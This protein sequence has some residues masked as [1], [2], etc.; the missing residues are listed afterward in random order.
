MVRR[1][2]ENSVNLLACEKKCLKV[3]QLCKMNIQLNKYTE[4]NTNIVQ[5]I[6]I[7]KIKFKNVLTTLKAKYII[8]SS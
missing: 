7:N 3:V 5:I 1:A 6:K 4:I 8:K 2:V